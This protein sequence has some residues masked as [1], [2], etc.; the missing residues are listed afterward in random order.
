MSTTK[1][2]SLI[3]SMLALR[4]PQCREGHLFENSTPYTFHKIGDTHAECP[5]CKANLKPEP[6]FYFGAAYV[7]WAL[8]VAQWIT[9]L[10]ALK[11]FDA[12][13][14]IDFGFLTH[15]GTFLLTGLIVSL[16]TFPYLF[17]LSRS[18]WAHFFI[19]PSEKSAV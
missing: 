13:G 10:V 15:P 3:G 7:S 19:K 5:V 4:C 8:T 12:L 14:W 11:V 2:R 6:G 17:R 16:I 9:V 1:Q 18:V